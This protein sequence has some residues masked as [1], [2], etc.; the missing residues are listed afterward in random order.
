MATVY[1]AGRGGETPHVLAYSLHF[2]RPIHW[3]ASHCPP[4]DEYAKEPSVNPREQLNAG[5]QEIARKLQ[6]TLK[7]KLSR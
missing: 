6:E 4:G 3:H 1:Q 7:R 5:A 2:C